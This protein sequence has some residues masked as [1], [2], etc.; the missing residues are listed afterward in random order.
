MKFLFG[1][2]QIKSR[3]LWVRYTIA[4]L[5]FPFYTPLP[6]S[7]ISLPHAT[8]TDTTTTTYGETEEDVRVDEIDE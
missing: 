7:F 2:S 3:S 5:L 8:Y 4:K 6:S 1:E